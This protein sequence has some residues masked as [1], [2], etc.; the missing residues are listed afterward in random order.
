MEYMR[1]KRRE[2]KRKT[3]VNRSRM[4]QARDLRGRPDGGPVPHQW[5]RV[6]ETPGCWRCRFLGR[7]PTLAF[8]SDEADLDSRLRRY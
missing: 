7:I 5:G 6:V 8:T 2:R 3:E 4:E 1:S